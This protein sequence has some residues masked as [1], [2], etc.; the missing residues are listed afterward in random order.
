MQVGCYKCSEWAP[1]KAR[2]MGISQRQTEA[3]YREQMQGRR[4]MLRRRHTGWRVKWEGTFHL[5]P[6]P[7][8]SGAVDPTVWAWKQQHQ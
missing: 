3:G 4:G 6:T 1:S 2:A 5:S 7:L 8:P